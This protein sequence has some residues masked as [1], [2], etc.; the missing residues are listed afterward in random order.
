MR[1][2]VTRQPVDFWDSARGL[3]PSICLLP[4]DGSACRHF[5][6]NSAESDFKSL[7]RTIIVLVE[8]PAFV[9]RMTDVPTPALISNCLM[10][11]SETPAIRASS[12]AVNSGS[13]VLLRNSVES[14]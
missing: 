13:L 12:K 8:L 6:P 1:R 4:E 9:R 14:S 2:G 10:Y 3:L 5:Q 7:K 11:R